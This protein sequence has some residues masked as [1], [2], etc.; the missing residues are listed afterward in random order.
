MEEKYRAELAKLGFTYRVEC[1]KTVLETRAYHNKYND[2]TDSSYAVLN[3]PTC[4]GA[5]TEDAIQKAVFETLA[6]CH[7]ASV[8][9]TH[10]SPAGGSRIYVREKGIQFEFS[11]CL[12]E[13]QIV[14]K[15][16]A[17]LKMGLDALKSVY[18]GYASD[19]PEAP[20]AKKKIARAYHRIRAIAIFIKAGSTS[21]ER[22]T[23]W[24]DPLE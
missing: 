18:E 20:A 19:D 13:A 1:V 11:E 16:M 6:I 2:I 23:E 4:F 8:K 3:M 21:Y 5:A 9:Q 14:E 7:Q 17:L 24:Y 15:M 22:K 12:S 10:F